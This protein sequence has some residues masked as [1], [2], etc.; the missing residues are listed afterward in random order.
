MDGHCG[1][2]PRRAEYTVAGAAFRDLRS[3]PDTAIKRLP[4]SLVEQQ[5]QSL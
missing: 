5:L 1:D 2:L 3:S 4:V